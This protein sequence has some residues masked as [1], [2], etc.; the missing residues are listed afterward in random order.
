MGF[1]RWIGV[2]A[3]L[4]VQ[5]Q[6]MPAAKIF[7]SRTYYTTANGNANSLSEAMFSIILT[8]A[9]D[10]TTFTTADLTV[11][12]NVDQQINI[13]SLLP[14]SGGTEATR[15]FTVKLSVA[16]IATQLVMEVKLAISETSTAVASDSTPYGFSVA[17]P[18]AIQGPDCTFV[19]LVFKCT[20][21]TDRD[22]YFVD[23]L[24]QTPTLLTKDVSPVKPDFVSFNARG[25]E[26]RYQSGVSSN[27]RM[28]WSLAGINLKDRFGQAPTNDFSDPVCLENPSSKSVC[29]GQWSEW[30]DC[31]WD[32]IPESQDASKNTRT[33]SLLLVNSLDPTCQQAE[34]ETCD[35]AKGLDGCKINVGSQETGHECSEKCNTFD[36]A[37]GC[38]CKAGCEQLGICCQSYFNECLSAESRLEDKFLYALA[39]C[40]EVPTLSCDTSTFTGPV[41]CNDRSMDYQCKQGGDC[42][43]KSNCCG[44]TAATC[45]TCAGDPL[46]VSSNC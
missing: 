27:V 28:C 22:V 20:T 21:A 14:K 45:D 4:S 25:F 3:L 2:L 40:W 23:R 30:S 26:L 7:S 15:A 9:I 35:T 10:P 5:V 43:A 36:A 39:P 8:E 11:S 17:T 37:T 42:V 44:G 29:G 32:C 19:S 16:A 31:V 24:S 33:R 6:A 41:V 1:V 46:F 13:V 12:T 38:S 18:F 34:T